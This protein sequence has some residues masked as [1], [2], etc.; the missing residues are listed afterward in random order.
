MHIEATEPD[1]FSIILRLWRTP[2]GEAGGD[3]AGWCSEIE[4]IQSGG[5]WK[6]ST[7]GELERF[8]YDFLRQPGGT[9]P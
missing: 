9:D 7:L 2:G 1:Y 5:H 3:E 8:L 6:F 4:H